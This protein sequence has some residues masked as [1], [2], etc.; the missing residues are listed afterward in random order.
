[1]PCLL[2]C[3]ALAFPRIALVLVWLF[4]PGYIG[5][6]FTSLLW[7]VLG[8]IFLPLTTLVYAWAINSHGAIDGLFLVALIVAVL[9]DLGLLGGG[10]SS[11]RTR[12]V[13][14]REE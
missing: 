7:P 9:V 14:V 3:V 1:M 11:R 5:G 13:T 8:F 10:A 12:V 2:G 4:V 6:A